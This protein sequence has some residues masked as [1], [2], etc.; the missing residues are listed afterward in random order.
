MDSSNQFVADPNAEMASRF[1]VVN[2][3]TQESE[4]ELGKMQQEQEQFV[5]QYQE[6]QKRAALINNLQ[7][8]PNG[9]MASPEMIAKLIKDKEH[10]D[11]ALRSRAQTL[12]VSRRNW[13]D[14][15]DQNYNAISALQQTVLDDELIKWKRGQQLGGNGGVFENNLEKIQEWCETL[16]E[17]IW[18]NRQQLR[19]VEFLFSQITLDNTGAMSETIGA[20]SKQI[21]SLLSSLVTSTFI[22]EKQPPQVMKTNT[23]FTS[24]IRLLV[25]GKL[26][27]ERKKQ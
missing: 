8:Q 21:T 6:S 3:R 20:C 7:T 15:H 5:I 26:N 11:V 18:Q 19:K 9:Q 23:R 10:M 4:Q 1:E 17:V 2:R 24:T 14:N 25:G 13:L 16:A 27:G 22:I 12:V